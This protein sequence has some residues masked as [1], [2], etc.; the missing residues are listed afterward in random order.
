M[1][2]CFHRASNYGMPLSKH[3]FELGQTFFTVKNVFTMV[4][5]MEKKRRTFEKIGLVFRSPIRVEIVRELYQSSPQRPVELAR[6]LGVSKQNV[7][8]HLKKLKEGGIV[9]VHREAM[10]PVVFNS[11][12]KRGVRINGVNEEGKIML[13]YGVELTE[14]GFNV[15]DMLY[16][17]S[18]NDSPL[19]EEA[20]KDE[21]EENDENEK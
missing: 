16:N 7:S 19:S 9:R 12:Y 15:A 14:N 20:V 4:R 5:S 10:P 3:L 21:K 6:K 17:F 18:V 1:L 11:L 13:S 2:S 8:Y